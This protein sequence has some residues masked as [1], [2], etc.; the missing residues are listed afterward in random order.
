MDRKY[1]VITYNAKDGTKQPIRLVK[2]IADGV[3]VLH[4]LWEDK[5]NECLGDVYSKVDMKYTFHEDDYAQICCED[6][7]WYFE[8]LP[9]EEVNVVRITR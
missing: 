4:N 1:G 2:T 9:L 7:V 6:S 3:T 5:L 8:I